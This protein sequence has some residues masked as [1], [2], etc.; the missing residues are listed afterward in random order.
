MNALKNSINWLINLSRV[1][2]NM[3]IIQ[4]IYEQ[5]KKYINNPRNLSNVKE[6]FHIIKNIYQLEFQGPTGPKF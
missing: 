2:R 4:D 3:S 5:S 6:I 1:K